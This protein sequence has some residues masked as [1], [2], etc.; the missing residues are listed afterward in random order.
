LSSVAYDNSNLIQIPCHLVSW[1]SRVSCSL[2][3]HT[4][5]WQGGGTALH[6]L[7]RT[8]IGANEHRFEEQR[9]QHRQGST[10]TLTLT[11]ILTLTLTITLNLTI[12]FNPPPN[13]NPNQPLNTPRS[14]WQRRDGPAKSH[15]SHTPSWR[16]WCDPSASNRGR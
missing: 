10:I 9:V 13:P 5:D 15:Q 8:R 6:S 7:H 14:S 3:A 4:H 2:C 1:R 16:L 12:T 11:L